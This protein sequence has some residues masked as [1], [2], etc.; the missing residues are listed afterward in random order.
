M[1]IQVGYHPILVHKKSLIYLYYWC[2][3]EALKLYS[4]SP[5]FQTWDPA[6]LRVYVEAGTYNTPTPSSSNTITK[7]KQPGLFEA[8]T[9]TERRVM[10]EVW[11]RLPALDK[12][13]E[14]R[15]L[16]PGEKEQPY[17]EEGRK[18]AQIRAW[19][20]PERASNVKID[21]AGHLVS[22]SFFLSFFC[23]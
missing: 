3:E 12:R 19:R 16:F 11:E 10:Q 4:Q 20:R 6:T 17:G 1:V 18:A 8:I 13:I 9:F 5:F 22:V 23:H 15:W 7:L 14:L 2:R 21:G